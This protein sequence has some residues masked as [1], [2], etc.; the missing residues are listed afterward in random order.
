MRLCSSLG[1]PGLCFG[2]GG[3]AEHRGAELL[4]EAEEEFEAGQLGGEGL[5][6]VAVCIEQ[7]NKMKKAAPFT[8]LLVLSNFV[9]MNGNSSLS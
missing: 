4:V 1:N 9:A 3:A 2:L 8:K 7:S 6:A 5:R